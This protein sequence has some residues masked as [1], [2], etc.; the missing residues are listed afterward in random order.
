VGALLAIP[1]MHWAHWC[2]PNTLTHTHCLRFHSSEWLSE[3]SALHHWSDLEELGVTS[4]DH[5]RLVTLRGCHLLDGLVVSP[6]SSSWRLWRSHRGDCEE[7]AP[8]SLEWQRRHYWNR[9]IVCFFIHLAQR[10]SGASIEEQV[11]AKN[12]LQHG[13]GV[14][15]KSPRPWEKSVSLLFITCFLAIAHY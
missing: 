12:R 2:F 9:G 1:S 8:T 6:S 11:R 10:S 15:G 7:F 3:S 13:L 5:H 14:I 4:S